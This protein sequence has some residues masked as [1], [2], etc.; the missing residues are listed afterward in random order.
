MPVPQFGVHQKM[1]TFGHVGSHTKVKPPIIFFF[2]GS[3]FKPEIKLSG[4]R[5]AA[6]FA[7][8]TKSLAASAVYSFK[9]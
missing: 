3:V 9:V 6:R 7:C 2:S 4:E 8:G 1:A 5:L